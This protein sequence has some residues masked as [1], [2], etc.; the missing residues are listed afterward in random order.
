[1]SSPCGQLSW[2]NSITENSF[3]EG[4]KLFYFCKTTHFSFFPKLSFHLLP[5]ILIHREYNSWPLLD[6]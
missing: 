4:E 3:S 2:L 1:M 5:T 6:I